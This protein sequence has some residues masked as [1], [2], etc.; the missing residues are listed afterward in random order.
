MGCR[1]S[2]TER[3]RAT[4]CGNVPLRNNEPLGAAR[5]KYS[6][7]SF[8]SAYSLDHICKTQQSLFAE[9]ILHKKVFPSTQPCFS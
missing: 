9:L 7:E 8:D 2:R 6:K 4:A 5:R 1:T 3:Q